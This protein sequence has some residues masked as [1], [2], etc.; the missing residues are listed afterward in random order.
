MRT[1]RREDQAAAFDQG[2]AY[3]CGTWGDRCCIQRCRRGD[4]PSR[5]R[6]KRDTETEQDADR[7]GNERKL[8]I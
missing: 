5:A 6:A 7:R 3:I 8:C 1:F 2:D 4:G